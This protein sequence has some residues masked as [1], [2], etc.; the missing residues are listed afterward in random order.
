MQNKDIRIF[1]HKDIFGIGSIGT[2]CHTKSR[3][4]KLLKIHKDFELYQV[5]IYNFLCQN[6]LI[7]SILFTER[8][9]TFWP[10][11]ISSIW[12]IRTFWIISSFYV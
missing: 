8:I 4:E 5:F 11:D 3:Q 1:R 7:F 6:I 9:E 12:G 2:F 10:R